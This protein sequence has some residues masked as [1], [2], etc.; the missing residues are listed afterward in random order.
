MA[1]LSDPTTAQGRAHS[2]TTGTISF[3]AKEGKFYCYFPAE[4]DGHGNII[5]EGA[6]VEVSNPKFMVV[7]VNFSRVTHSHPGRV[8]WV[9]GGEAGFVLPED[10][11]DLQAN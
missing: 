6:N 5:K 11:F 1:S 9:R 2:P 3:N 7:G 8:V 4:K 10:S